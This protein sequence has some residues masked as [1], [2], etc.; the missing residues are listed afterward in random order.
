MYDSL[1]TVIEAVDI[2]TVLFR[3]L[4][5]QLSKLGRKGQMVEIA[6]VQRCPSWR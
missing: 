2:N 4:S 6:Q 3:R 5:G 1:K